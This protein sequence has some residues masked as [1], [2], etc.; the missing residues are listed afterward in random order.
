MKIKGNRLL[1]TRCQHIDQ[2]AVAHA[3]LQM[4]PARFYTTNVFHVIC[5]PVK[6]GGILYNL[7]VSDSLIHI[8]VG[9]PGMDVQVFLLI[10]YVGSEI[11]QVVKHTGEAKRDNYNKN[12]SNDKFFGDAR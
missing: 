1:C 2:V 3:T 7:L 12:K 10:R 5:R 11:A 8:L 6:A 9:G 4:I